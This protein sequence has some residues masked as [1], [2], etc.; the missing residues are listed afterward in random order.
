VSNVLRHLLLA[1]ALAGA[2]ACALTAPPA[3]AATICGEGMYSYVGY[4]GGTMTNGVSATIRQAGPLTVYN[5]HVAGWIGVVQPSG[6]R[7]WLQVGLSAFPGQA[8]SEIYYEVDVPGQAPVYHEVAAAVAPGR[9]HTFAV[10]EQAR[11]PGWWVVWIDGR[12]VS[13]P[14]HLAGSHGRWT[15]QVLG[16]S[17]AGNVSGACNA[18]SYAFSGVTLH[19][20]GRAVRETLPPKLHHDPYYVVADRTRSGFVAASS[21]AGNPRGAAVEQPGAPQSATGAASQPPQST[22]AG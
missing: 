6:A 12:P 19:P 21:G 10:L 11:R 8:R 5:G 1:A 18:Y 20:A 3:R 9:S 7:G 2:G 13:A 14:V 22:N 15:A 16:E 17:F 4:T